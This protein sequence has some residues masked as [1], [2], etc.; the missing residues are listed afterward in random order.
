M[1]SKVRRNVPNTQRPLHAAVVGMRQDKMFQRLAE[2]LIPA[3]AL[4]GD[5]PRI[6]ARMKMERIN[7]I[8]MDLRA[9]GL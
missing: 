4:P 7:Q 9:L 6:M 3:L 8:A 1:V 5:G 2:F